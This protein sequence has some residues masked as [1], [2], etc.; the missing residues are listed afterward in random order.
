MEIVLNNNIAVSEVIGSAKDKLIFCYDSNSVIKVPQEYFEKICN[1][2]FFDLPQNLFLILLQSEVILSANEYHIHAEMRDTL[3]HRNNENKMIIH[4]EL[5]S[6]DVLTHQSLKNLNEKV[7]VKFVLSINE[8]DLIRYGFEMD[9]KL[10][11]ITK[12]LL[13]IKA[14]KKVL[15]IMLDLR[16]KHSPIKLHNIYSF[17]LCHREKINIELAFLFEGGSWRRVGC[18]QFEV[19]K[20]LNNE[21]LSFFLTTNA[22]DLDCLEE[23]KLIQ[24]LYENH[25]FIP[26]LERVYVIRCDVQ[27][28][29]LTTLQAAKEIESF[30]TSYSIKNITNMKLKLNYTA[31]ILKLIA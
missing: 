23:R 26:F 17:V 4:L 14:S 15:K 21:M 6:Y 24:F 8:D 9:G 30:L 25:I 16:E 13:E 31:K 12:Y 27:S 11:D 3:S 28:T 29:K 5:G 18:D 20:L 22:Q 2:K 1:K 7:E 19:L 10:I